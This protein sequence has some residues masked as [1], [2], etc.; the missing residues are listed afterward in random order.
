MMFELMLCALA[1]PAQNPEPG[2]VNEEFANGMI[3]EYEVRLYEDGSRRRDGSFTLSA[4]TGEKL[5]TG[6]YTDGRKSGRWR[7]RYKDGKPR[8]YGPYRK[9][10]RRGVW[11]FHHSNGEKQAKGKYLLGRPK[12]E[13]EFWNEAGK[14]DPRYSGEYDWVDEVDLGAGVTGSGMTLGGLA[15]GPWMCRWPNG[16]T[17]LEASFSRGK[18]S[19][20][21]RYWHADGTYDSAFL[22]GEYGSDSI[23]APPLDDPIAVEDIVAASTEAET[24]R[25]LD[26]IALGD[27]LPLNRVE[28]NW[29]AYYEDFK[30]G[31]SGDGD[32]AFPEIAG[33]E[34]A[35]L[36]LL[37]DE[38]KDLDYDSNSD[39]ARANLLMQKVAAP[40]C[41]R[42]ALVSANEPNSEELRLGA[43]RLHSI[44]TLASNAD[45]WWSFDLGAT[46]EEGM[47]APSQVL[48]SP[49]TRLEQLFAGAAS[50][51]IYALRYAKDS[52]L[53]KDCRIALDR[54]LAW[55][56][57]HQD[58]DGR[59][60]ADEF[61]KRDPL[62][63]A[64]E[65]AGQPAHDVG[66]TGLAVLALLGGGH[67]ID[68][69]LYSDSVARA[70]T[71]LCTQQSESTGLIGAKIGIAFHYGHAIATMALSEAYD[72]S[73]S[74]GLR[75]SAQSGLDYTTLAR[76]R[77]GVWRYEEP[78]VGDND[79][80]V[81]GW[82]VLALTTGL[83]AGLDID[84]D[85]L[86]NAR[87]WLDEIT[88]ASTGRVGYSA[89][90]EPSSRTPGINDEHPRE[91]G[92]AM[93][94]LGLHCRYLMG[95]VP[96]TNKIMEK[97]A[98]LL[99]RKL[100][101]W[102]KDGLSVDLYYWFHATYAMHYMGGPSAEAWQEALLPAIL[103]SQRGDGSW[104]PNG[105]WGHA[106]G[107]VYSTALMALMLEAPIRYA[108]IPDGH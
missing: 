9:G 82:M 80:S 68:S 16:R 21:W 25:P 53:E 35:V 92:E 15:H 96:S 54:A 58:E 49:P 71:W 67:S 39:L 36:P 31:L 76:N 43:L 10:S 75:V 51:E 64:R 70:V 20:N 104:D 63:D 2:T 95:Q 44:H 83:R 41:G 103:H 5:V 28:S 91:S 65:G 32:G 81:T 8:A 59:W 14:R 33:D 105:A 19:G 12:G 26:L 3:A 84:H 61:M 88:D 37:L 87:R 34:R 86:A 73:G 55:L 107:R 102:S 60:D 56:V 74:P 108:R 106:G 90:G 7:F 27:C 45:M 89:I 66:V 57:A 69:G 1:L 77:R 40:I 93:T 42:H 4:A 38:L 79:T 100:P 52:L 72:I 78:P 11:T 48:L 101:E 50:Q 97:H 30:E 23:V 17:Q 94:A 29:K 22:T 47:T 24:A 13:W 6:E 46:F 98:A 99:K 85:S 18:R 62:A